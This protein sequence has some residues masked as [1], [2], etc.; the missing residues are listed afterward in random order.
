MRREREREDDQAAGAEGGIE[1]SG[2]TE[3]GDCV[4]L[5]GHHSFTHGIRGC[6]PAISA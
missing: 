4:L 6:S 5:C 1:R 2:W 3:R